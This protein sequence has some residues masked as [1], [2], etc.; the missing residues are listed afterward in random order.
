[1]KVT[2]VSAEVTAPSLCKNKLPIKMY[3]PNS[4]YSDNYGTKWVTEVF[5]WL[6]RKKLAGIPAPCKPV[7]FVVTEEY[8]QS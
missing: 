3:I 4:E 6:I 1:M 2:P 7:V 8:L 5:N